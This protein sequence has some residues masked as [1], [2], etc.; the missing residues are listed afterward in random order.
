MR[1]LDGTKTYTPSYLPTYND[2]EIPCTY[3]YAPPVCVYVHTC[4]QKLQ[5]QLQ[6]VSLGI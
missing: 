3:I 1:E 2:Q 4:V 5:L 6:A